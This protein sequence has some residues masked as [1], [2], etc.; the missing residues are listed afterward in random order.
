MDPENTIEGNGT[1]YR[2][3]EENYRK[4]R[5][6]FHSVSISLLI[7]TGVVF[8]FI[9][10]Q[11]ATMRQQTRQLTT[12]VAEFEQSGARTA[13]DELRQKLYTFSQENQDFRPIFVRYFGTNPP[14]APGPV[15]RP[16]QTDEGA[17]R[18]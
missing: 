1:S 7:L 13:I 17:L 3:L 4:L 6:L 8:V 11:V 5:Y 14:T 12:E 9:Y 10:R 15:I 18:E 16:A 2:A